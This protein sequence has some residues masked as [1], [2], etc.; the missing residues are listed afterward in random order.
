MKRVSL[1]ASVLVVLLGCFGFGTNQVFA[2]EKKDLNNTQSQRL[3]SDEIINVNGENMEVKLSKKTIGNKEYNVS[4]V[5]SEEGTMIFTYNPENDKIKVTSEDLSKSDLNTIQS[6]V[7]QMVKDPLINESEINESNI[8]ITTLAASTWYNGQ[9]I[10][11]KVTADTKF[12][13]Q[14][15]IGMLGAKFGLPG[16]VFAGIANIAIQYGVKVGYYK[17]RT[18][19]RVLDANYLEYRVYSELYKDK[20]YTKKVGK[21]TVSYTK[22][23]AGV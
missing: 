21:T 14:T 1:L 11:Y 15:I 23:W 6:N 12:T 19:V 7:D 17:V 8:T 5:K 22:V 16:A 18:D 2:K 4:E 3:I 9:W 20:N 10:K 13:V